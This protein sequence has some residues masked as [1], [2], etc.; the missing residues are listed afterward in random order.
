[1]VVLLNQAGLLKHRDDGVEFSVVV[2]HGGSVAG[3]QIWVVG[4]RKMG[5]GYR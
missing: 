4:N 5:G 1:M 2:S 3:V